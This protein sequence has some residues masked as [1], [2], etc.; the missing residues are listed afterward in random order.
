MAVVAYFS[1]IEVLSGLSPTYPIFLVLRLLYGIGMEDSGSWCV[2]DYGERT[3]TL[4]GPAF[5]L[6]TG[7]V[8]AGLF[9]CCRGGAIDPAR[10]GLAAM[11]WA[12]LVPG[13]ITMLI[14]YKSPESEAWKQ[15]RVP[16]VWGIAQS[17]LGSSQEFF[18]SMVLM[19]TLMIGLSHGTQD[20]LSGFSK[21]RAPHFAE[22]RG[23]L[24]M[25]YNVGALL[26]TIFCRPQFRAAG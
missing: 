8:P 12:G 2:T 7:R 6:A 23:Y 13:V 18:L 1:L 19:L 11:F 15:H 21:N 5:R 4:A 22:C 9:A 3:A 26:G 14:A 10:V 20:L 24:A 17:C 25:F 16:S